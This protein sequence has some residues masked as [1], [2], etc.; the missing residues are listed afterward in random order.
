MG[1][2]ERQGKRRDEKRKKGKEGERREE[3]E[4]EGRREIMG[5]RNVE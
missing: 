2:K 5:M 3:K 4:R 1:S